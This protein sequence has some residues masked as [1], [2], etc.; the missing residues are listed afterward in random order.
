[1]KLS[2]EGGIIEFKV[3]GH[4]PPIVF[5]HGFMET[6]KVWRQY[7]EKL[8]PRFKVIRIN[9]PGHGKSSV[10][11]KT[12]SMEFMAGAVNAVLNETGAR[13]ALFVGHSMG[14]YVSLAFAELWPEKINGLVLFSSTCFADSTARKKDR[15]RGLRILESQKM[16]FISSVIPNLFY[17]KSGK[18]DAKNIYRFIKIASRQPKEGIMAALRGMMTR[19]DRSDVLKKL[20]APLLF[21]GGTHDILIPTEKIYEMH[22]FVPRSEVLLLERSGHMGFVEQKRDSLIAI[23]S[24]AVQKVL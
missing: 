5:L 11:H 21:L 3:A 18:K 19:K 8:S 22:S 23:K 12:H 4:G 10:F 1:M 13:Q 7:A 16:K 24:F 2:F 6:A 17:Q 20:K 14:G 15:E 9:L